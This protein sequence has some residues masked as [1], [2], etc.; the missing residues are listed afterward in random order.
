[1]VRP[2]RCHVCGLS[3]YAEKTTSLVVFVACQWVPIV[4]GTSV[5]FWTMLF[6]YAE[7]LDI[8]LASA[9]L[10]SVVLPL[11]RW[12]GVGDTLI[13]FSVFSLHALVARRSSCY[14]TTP[15]LQ[16]SLLYVWSG[17][18]MRILSL[19]WMVGGNT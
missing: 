9:S 6:E 18:C 17:I 15:I 11:H 2:V 10:I 3:V 12:I 16:C 5:V 4:C 8:W 13:L 14:R 19:P 1:V 7:K